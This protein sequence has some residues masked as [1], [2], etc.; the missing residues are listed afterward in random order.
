MTS[1][2]AAKTERTLWSS[3]EN[4][5]CVHPIG[6]NSWRATKNISDHNPRVSLLR[7]LFAM[8]WLCRSILTRPFPPPLRFQISSSTIYD[9]NNVLHD[10]NDEYKYNWFI[11]LPAVNASSLMWQHL[12]KSLPGWKIL[13]LPAARPHGVSVPCICLLHWRSQSWLFFNTR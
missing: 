8:K 6:N 3:R 2:F 1:D 7:I 13:L 12:H 9:I 11:K 10:R 5:W 4:Y